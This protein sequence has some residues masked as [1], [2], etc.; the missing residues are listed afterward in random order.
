MRGTRRSS[1]GGGWI[2]RS[3]TQQ[4]VFPTH[5]LPPFQRHQRVFA[6]WSPGVWKPAT[7]VKLNDDGTLDLNMDETGAPW[8]NASPADLA[9]LPPPQ[10]LPQQSMSAP[11]LPQQQWM[12]AQQQYGFIANAGN[13]TVSAVVAVVLPVL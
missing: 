1:P 13:V 10:S 7:I 11:A 3:P 5:D 12:A 9:I 6:L 8:Y 4:P 2:P